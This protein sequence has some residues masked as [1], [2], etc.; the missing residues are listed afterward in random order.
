MR[1]LPILMTGHSEG[2]Y[3]WYLMVS[4]VRKAPGQS[5]L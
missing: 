4:D 2:D 5:A 3:S 1:L